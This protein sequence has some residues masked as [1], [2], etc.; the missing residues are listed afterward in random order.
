LIVAA[1]YFV[2]YPV[3]KYAW[4]MAHYLLGLRALAHDVWFY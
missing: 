1:G 2:R 3:G 4:Q